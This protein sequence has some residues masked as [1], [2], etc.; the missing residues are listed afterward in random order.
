MPNDR[1]PHFTGPLGGEGN[2]TDIFA[3]REQTGGVFGVW[4][5]TIV[6][7]FGPPLHIHKTEDEFFYILSG[8]FALQLGDCVKLAKAGSF[9]F[10]PKNAPHTYKNIGTGRG[11]LGR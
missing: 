7:K 10:F 9:A 6:P 3:T 4:R 11:P 5:S 8:E 1:V 2:T